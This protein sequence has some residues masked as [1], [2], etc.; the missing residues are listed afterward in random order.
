MNHRAN[1]TRRRA[2]RTT[3]ALAFV[4]LAGAGGSSCT[5]QS[6]VPEVEPVTEEDIRQRL[7]WRGP[8]LRLAGAPLAEVV[9][10]FNRMNRLQLVIGDPALADLRFSGSFPAD[11]IEGFVRVL[12]GNYGIKGEAAGHDTIVLRRQ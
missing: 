5:C 11:N 4:L 7:H 10:Q 3:L 8:K 9:R 6:P 2:I 1:T 12:A